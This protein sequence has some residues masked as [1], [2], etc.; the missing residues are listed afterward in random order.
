MKRKASLR[1]YNAARQRAAVWDADP[2]SVGCLQELDLYWTVPHFHKHRLQKIVP[3]F[4][5]WKPDF[6]TWT[7]IFFYKKKNSNDSP[8]HTYV[9]RHLQLPTSRTDLDQHTR[10]SV[11][12]ADR[13]PLIREN[14]K[15]VWRI[16]PSLKSFGMRY[17]GSSCYFSVVS[18][19]SFASA[20]VLRVRKLFTIIIFLRCSWRPSGGYRFGHDSLVRWHLSTRRLSNH[21]EWQG[22]SCH[23]IGCVSASLCQ[24]WRVDQHCIVVFLLY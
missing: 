16:T 13:Q 10:F 23:T 18:F 9:I 6:Q 15:Y 7:Q 19:A 20:T 8:P 11:R 21:C 12:G 3:K 2:V 5:I 24:F 1:I 14:Q 4:V 22:Q 17:V